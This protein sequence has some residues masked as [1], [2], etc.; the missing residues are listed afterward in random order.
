MTSCQMV[1]LLPKPRISNL[2]NRT[3]CAMMLLKSFI[4]FRRIKN[5]HSTLYLTQ[6][7]NLLVMFLHVLLGT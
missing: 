7:I 2:G 1:F 4:R 6:L 5:V 3:H